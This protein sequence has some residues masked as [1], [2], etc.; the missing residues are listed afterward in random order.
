[1]RGGV[2][3]AHTLFKSPETMEAQVDSQ[4][5]GS[6]GSQLAEGISPCG[7]SGI[8][9]HCRDPL[10]TQFSQEEEEQ[11][12]TNLCLKYFSSRSSQL[13]VTLQ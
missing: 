10:S 2:T 6:G 13:S 12:K 11:K 9:G 5:N 8:Q 3:N 1:M 4:G 7:G